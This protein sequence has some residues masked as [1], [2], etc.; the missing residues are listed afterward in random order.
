MLFAL[1]L[2]CNS[3]SSENTMSDV[4]SYSQSEYDDAYMALLHIPGEEFTF[5]NREQ[6]AKEH[7][8]YISV[9]KKNGVLFQCYRQRPCDLD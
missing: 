6:A 9:L 5:G 1:F 3:E 7:K 8:G 2:S 4:M